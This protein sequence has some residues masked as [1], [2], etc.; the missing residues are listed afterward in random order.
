LKTYDSTVLVYRQTKAEIVGES[1]YES[2]N[3]PKVYL[4][5]VGIFYY[6]SRV[7]HSWKRCLLNCLIKLY[8][9]CF[10]NFKGGARVPPL[11]PPLITILNM[12]HWWFSHTNGVQV[13]IWKLGKITMQGQI[14]LL[15]LFICYIVLLSFL[16]V[17]P[18][19]QSIW[20]QMYVIHLIILLNILGVMIDNKRFV[21]NV[22]Y[23][24]SFRYKVFTRRSASFWHLGSIIQILPKIPHS[25][26]PPSHLGTWLCEGGGHGSEAAVSGKL[27]WNHKL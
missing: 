18:I 24:L 20:N 3:T 14:L 22:L 6:R 12:S 26:C 13:N 9:I 8:N 27:V 1:I 15:Y 10:A 4:Q 5:C 19:N 2:T 23:Q 16:V 21:F 17:K 11:N 7:N 25:P